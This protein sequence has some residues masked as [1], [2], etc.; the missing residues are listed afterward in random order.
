MVTAG[1]RIERRRRVLN[2]AVPD[3]LKFSI[4]APPPARPPPRARAAREPAGRGLQRDGARAPG[5][6]LRQGPARRLGARPVPRIAHTVRDRLVQRWLA[7]QRTY[8]EQDVKRAC[9][10]S[11][12]FLTG[13]SLGPVPDEHGPVRGGARASRPT[14]GFDL[15]AMLECEGDPGLG[16]GGLGRLAAC[17]MDSLA[18]LGA[19]RRSATASAT[20]SASSSSASSDGQQVEQPRQLAAVRQPVGDAAPRGRADV[21]FYGRVA[22]PPTTQRAGMRASW[23]DT[24]QRDRPAVRL[25]HRRPRDRHGEHAAAVVGARHARLRPA[26]LQR[27]RLPARGRREDRHREHLQGALP[28]R[29][30]PRRA[31]SCG[32][33]SSTSSSPARSPT[34]CGATSA[35]QRPSTTCRDKVAIQLNDT[36]PAIAV[37]ELMRVLVDEELLDWDAAWEITEAHHRATPTTRCCPRRSSTGRC[38]MFERAAAAA[39]ADH[40]RDQPALPA[41]GADA[42][43]G[44]HRAHAAHVASSKRAR[45][46]QIRMAHLATVGCA[47]H[48]RRGQAAHRADQER[49]AARLLRAVAGA[50]QQQDQRRHAAALAAATPT[51]G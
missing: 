6:H 37:A 26:A 47:Q 13:R 7:T 45:E 46:K 36:H 8:F 43:A 38:A 31:R 9:Y 35:A 50:L 12:E 2:M 25:V 44:E 3:P 21:R 16:N 28:E 24:Q 29:P 49:A 34:S 48:Q 4:E 5:P 14:Q 30:Q 18:T 40:L 39:P 22:V 17:F 23:V 11:S 41:Q 51:R 19:A 42:L 27:G 15:G 33:S 20:S 10:L 1:K 32:S